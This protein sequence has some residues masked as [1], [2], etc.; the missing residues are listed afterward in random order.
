MKR[1]DKIVDQ[2]KLAAQNSETKEFAAMDKVWSRVEEKLDRKE[3]KKAML[4]WKKIAVA[5]CLLLLG[6]LGYQFLKEEQPK[7]ESNETI[8]VKDS[9]NTPTQTDRAV[10]VTKVLNPEIKNDAVQILEKQIKPETQ[11]VM[12]GRFEIKSEADAV[13]DVAPPESGYLSSPTP[14]HSIIKENAVTESKKADVEMMMQNRGK[15]SL[16]HKD[17]PLVVID[18]K[19]VQ[20]KI[21]DVQF[22]DDESLVVLNEPL[23]IINGVEY[24][25]KEVFGP[26]PTSPYSPLKKQEIETISILQDEKATEIY[27]EKGKKGVVIITTKNGKPLSLKKEK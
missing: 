10:V 8:V 15:A 6:T 24:T 3:D 27:G 5:A 4:L 13:N 16:V 12:E 14:R 23:Y 21:Q 26:N 19:I 1:E 18:K 25:E 9:I 22:T 11:V 2:F 7:I 20:A 17:E